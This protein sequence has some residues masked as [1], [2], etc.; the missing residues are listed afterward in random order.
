[1]KFATV[2]LLRKE[3]EVRCIPIS[4]EDYFFFIFLEGEIEFE[5]VY[6]VK[7]AGRNSKSMFDFDDSSELLLSGPVFFIFK[8]VNPFQSK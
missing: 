4:K 8:K 6:N 1:M 3:P 2:M 7:K 5:Q